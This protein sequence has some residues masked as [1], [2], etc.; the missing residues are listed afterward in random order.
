MIKLVPGNCQLNGKFKITFVYEVLK[1]LDK[2]T[3]YNGDGVTFLK[4]V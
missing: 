2:A 1:C 4:N 3:L